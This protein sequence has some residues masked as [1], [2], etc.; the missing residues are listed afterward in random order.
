MPGIS[1][2]APLADGHW[3]AVVDTKAF[4]AAPRFV[5][6]DPLDVPG[7]LREVAVDGWDKAGA[8]SNDLE[9]L[10]ALAGHPGEFLATESGYYQGQYGRLFHVR[11]RQQR[12]EILAV[13]P[14][15]RE[16]S[17]VERGAGFEGLACWPLGRRQYLLALGERGSSPL[18]PRASVRFGVFHQARRQTQWREDEAVLEIPAHWLDGTRL[19]GIADL[20]ADGD[21]RLWAVST[22][23]PGDAGP[24]RSVIW[25]PGR[26]GRSLAAPVEWLPHPASGWVVDGFKIEA[27]SAPDTRI[28]GSVL[29]IGSEDEQLGGSWRALGVP[30]ALP[31]APTR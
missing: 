5:A 19:R 13:M 2:M 28:H 25:S 17:A 12:L 18:R 16:R 6:F 4:S 29:S 9:A 23:D 24:F 8:P 30:V 14:L 11:Y 26:L 20:Y 31:P 21:G 15:P 3:L 10:C 1:G 7:S 22:I 27:L